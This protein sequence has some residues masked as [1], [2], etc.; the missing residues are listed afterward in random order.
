MITR[1][2]VRL[3]TNGY[4]VIIGRGI[5]K[6]FPRH[7]RGLGLGKDAVIVS[8]LLV[9]RLHGAALAASLRKAGY[10]VKAFHVPEGEASK[11]AACALRLIERIAAY[12]V[13]KKIFIIALGGGVIGDLAGLVAAIYKRGV[14]YVQVPTTL[15]AQVDSSIGGKTA[16]DLK[17]G[18]NLVGAFYQPRLVVSDTR[19]LA[20]L[21]RRQIQNGLAEAVK[22]GVIADAKF[23]AYIEKNYRKLLKGDAAALTHVVQRSSRIKADVVSRDEKETRGLRTILNFGHTLGHALEAAGHFDRYHHGESVA[24]GMRV[25]AEI[26]CAVSGLAPRDAGRLNALLTA[27]GLPE[28]IEKVRLPDILDHMRHDKKFV[29]GRNR[30]VLVQSIGRVG[31]VANVP[32][33]LITRAIRSLMAG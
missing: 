18:K 21:S 9:E 7:I 5:L 13:D 19:V 8:H 17:Y 14:P 11:S 27:I 20:T 6:D 33:D 29:A 3:K 26:S 4:D 22:Y 15:L 30:F 10:T 1:V 2:R 32:R 24:L 23:F 16:I 28:K 12:D 25:A 31:V